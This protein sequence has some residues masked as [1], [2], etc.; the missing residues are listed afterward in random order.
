MQST[1]A[2]EPRELIK[3]MIEIYGLP[4]IVLAMLQAIDDQVIRSAVNWQNAPLAKHWAICADACVKF[5]ATVVKEF[6]D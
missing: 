1:I 5:E 3:T 2:E 4:K 6:G